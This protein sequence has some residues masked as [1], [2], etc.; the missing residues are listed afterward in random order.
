MNQTVKAQD[1]KAPTKPVQ[2]DD[3][4][5]CVTMVDGRVEN[6]WPATGFILTATELI[7]IL[8]DIPVAYFPRD[9]VC[10]ATRPNL[11]PP[12]FF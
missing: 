1:P 4:R 3:L 10:Y 9:R 11:A 2:Q 12:A 8:G 5:F 7:A 6:V